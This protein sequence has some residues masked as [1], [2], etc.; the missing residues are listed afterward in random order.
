MI[1]IA[2]NS[3]EVLP[4]FNKV[5]FI[6]KLYYGLGGFII[7]RTYCTQKTLVITKSLL[8]VYS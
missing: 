4:V 5:S 1:P 3:E 2:A 7:A 6:T 8:L